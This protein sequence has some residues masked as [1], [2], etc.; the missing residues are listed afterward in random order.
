MNIYTAPTVYSYI[1]TA[2]IYTATAYACACYC[3][4]GASVAGGAGLFGRG[5]RT[6]VRPYGSRWG[7]A[8]ASDLMLQSYDN[9]RIYANFY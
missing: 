9:F 3:R 4:I 2:T 5:G 1:Y 7:C 6:R 8:V